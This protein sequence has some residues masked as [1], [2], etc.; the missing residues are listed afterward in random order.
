MTAALSPA[1]RHPVP[2]VLAVVLRDGC[3]LLVQRA[4]PPDAGLWGYP[5]GKIETGE[6]VFAA[7][8]RELLEE[9]GIHARPLRVLTAL[10][11]LDHDAAGTLRFHYILVAVLCEAESL[12]DPRAADDALDAR[13]IDLDALHRADLPLSRGVAD[14]ASLAQAVVTEL[15]PE[16]RCDG[17]DFIR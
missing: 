6:T 17:G 15:R 10:D 5:G 9:T 12:A 8:R 1:P 7:A 2:A 11:A 3:A 4:N 14:L 16:S 13:F